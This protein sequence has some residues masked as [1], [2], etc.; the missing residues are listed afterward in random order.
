M[1]ESRLTAQQKAQ[2]VQRAKGCCKYCQSQEDFSPDTFSVEHITPRSDGGTFD[3]S[4]LALACQGCNNRKYTSTAWADPLTGDIVP[5][6]HARQH[7]WSDHFAWN[8]DYTLLVG[9][10]PTGRATIEKLDLNRSGVVHLRRVLHDIGEHPP[11]GKAS[12]ITD[13]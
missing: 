11:P 10:T 5:L 4:N 1:S 6:Y 3:L 8:H 13:G 12:W 2:V 7:S 9:L